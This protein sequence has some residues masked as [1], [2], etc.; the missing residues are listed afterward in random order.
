MT[1]YSP[2]SDDLDNRLALLFKELLKQ[3]KRSVMNA[4][5]KR[6]TELRRLIEQRE[7]ELANEVE[8]ERLFESYL[9]SL[10]GDRRPIRNL[11]KWRMFGD[12]E[13]DLKSELASWKNEL[14][15]LKNRSIDKRL[16]FN[17]ARSKVM[18]L[19]QRT[20][21]DGSL[22]PSDN[23]KSSGPQGNENVQDYLIPIIQLMRRGK[24]HEEAFK[25]IANKLKVNYTT[26]SAQCTRGLGISS[27]Q[28]FIEHVQ[29][30]RIIQIM[31]NKY[32]D[33]RE[34]IERELG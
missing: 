22:W 16:I 29:S 23:S 18:L 5:D 2:I 28:T 9:D 14:D 13:D 6:Y 1:E 30:D 31:K 32:P 34:L 11:Q 12:W 4:A 33:K 8:L 3:E 19:L 24:R 26:V 27:V 21:Q 15:K 17:N 7:A 10:P 25:A 20:A